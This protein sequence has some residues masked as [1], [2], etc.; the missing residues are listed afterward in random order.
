MA[1]AAPQRCSRPWGKPPQVW[2][3]KEP[4]MATARY[5][6]WSSPGWYR[7]PGARIGAANT[8]PQPARVTTHRPKRPGN[9]Y[10][11]RTAR[12]PARVRLLVAAFPARWTAG[13]S[14][15]DVPDEVR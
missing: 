1:N 10:G 11:D 9:R 15:V 8:N 12:T 5:W 13:P 6:P 7:T 14:P 4:A 3:P 2:S